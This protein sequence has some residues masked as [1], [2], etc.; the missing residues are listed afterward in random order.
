MEQA[1]MTQAMLA[2]VV[3]TSQPS[4]WKL[5]TGK[6]NTSRKLVEI[7][8]ALNVRPEWLSTGNE[9]IRPE[10]STSLSEKDV[11][12]DKP[13]TNVIVWDD[14]TPLQSD[15]VE[16]PYLKDIELAAGDG[17]YCDEDYNGLTMRFSKNVLRRV[18]ANT[19]GSG[20]LC[21]PARGN[22][23]EP[24]LPDGTDVA[25]DCNNK[26]IDDGKLYAINVDGLKRVK[27]LY[28]RPGG[29]VVIR[30]YNR[31]EFQ[32]EETSEK[33]LEIIGRVFWYSVVL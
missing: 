11:K 29:K 27:A 1:G 21:F 2:A 18:G 17:S 10:Q 26:R 3:G 32:D 4:I 13:K 33:D 23:M 8:N 31:E 16:V 30:S 15:E 19:D 6:T 12:Q 24:I 20:V 5:T 7:A 22:S 9:P 28:R 25:V 14:D